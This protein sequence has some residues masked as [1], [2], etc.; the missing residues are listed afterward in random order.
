MNKKLNLTDLIYNSLAI[1]QKTFTGHFDKF[2]L[3]LIY[4]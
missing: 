4:A 2:N 1:R 3:S